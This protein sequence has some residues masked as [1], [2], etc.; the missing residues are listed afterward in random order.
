[1]EKIKLYF[2]E[3]MSLELLFSAIKIEILAKKKY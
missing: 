3:K 1:M 2:K